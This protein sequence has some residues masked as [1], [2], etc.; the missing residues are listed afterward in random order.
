MDNATTTGCNWTGEGGG[1]G[2]GSHGISSTNE[3]PTMAEE[4]G[5]AAGGEEDGQASAPAQADAAAL[6]AIIMDSSRPARL[7]ALKSILSFLTP[8]EV[9]AFLDSAIAPAEQPFFEGLRQEGNEDTMSCVCD[10]LYEW[11]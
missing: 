9:Q 11:R 10:C 7:D 4:G 2:G 3:T 5:G 1:G 6:G 8:G